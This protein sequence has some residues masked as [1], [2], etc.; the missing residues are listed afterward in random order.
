MS[1]KALNSPFKIIGPPADL[2]LV[3]QIR[4]M[5]VV[6]L[7]QEVFYLTMFKEDIPE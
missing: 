2:E 7:A 1:I 3:P 6:G 4:A 5:Q